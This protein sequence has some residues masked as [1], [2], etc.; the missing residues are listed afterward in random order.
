M[1]GEETVDTL[2]LKPGQAV[3]VEVECARCESYQWRA[4]NPM[5]NLR[6][7]LDRLERLDVQSLRDDQQV[8]VQE[9]IFFLAQGEHDARELANHAKESDGRPQRQDSLDQQLRDAHA[10]MTLMGCYDAADAIKDQFKLFE[11]KG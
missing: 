9:A 8:L 7:G 3:Q 5:R 2:Y 6:R 11:R 1:P 4:V 10:M